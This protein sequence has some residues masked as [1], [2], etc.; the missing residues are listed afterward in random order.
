MTN[1][2]T[3]KINVTKPE[4]EERVQTVLEKA[5]GSKL[6]KKARKVVNESMVTLLHG[7]NNAGQNEHNLEQFWHSAKTNSTTD[8]QTLFQCIESYY[9][10]DDN[11]GL[12]VI[13]GKNLRDTKR[14]LYSNVLDDLK[15]KV[16]YSILASDLKDKIEDS[17]FTMNNIIYLDCCT[18]NLED[19]NEDE[20]IDFMSFS[21]NEILEIQEVIFNYVINL[22]T[23][24]GTHSFEEIPSNEKPSKQPEKREITICTI[25]ITNNG[26]GEDSGID[27][28]EVIN[29]TNETEHD[30]TLIEYFQNQVQDSCENRDESTIRDILLS[31]NMVQ[32][33]ISSYDEDEDEYFKEYDIEEISNWM[34][35]N[36]RPNELVS[37]IDELSYNMVNITVE[38]KTEYL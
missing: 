13:N 10:E 14:K 37:L 19:F 25:I 27:N 2:N 36:I 11:E 23:I 38:Y 21:C 12:S 17:G 3:L 7:G 22:P 32:E 5:I 15:E 29:T 18:K 9:H 26:E 24:F 34:T 4:F 6:T 30:Q 35:E 8:K 31:S 16:S 1:Q 28:V 20:L 33:A